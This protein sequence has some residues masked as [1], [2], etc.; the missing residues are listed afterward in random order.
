MPTKFVEVEHKQLGRT[1]VPE[2]RV[3]HMG[4]DWAVVVD[5]K[6]KRKGDPKRITKA[7]TTAESNPEAGFAGEP[8]EQES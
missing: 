5:G 1:F 4:D 2:T 6:P 3:Q 8:T 7:V